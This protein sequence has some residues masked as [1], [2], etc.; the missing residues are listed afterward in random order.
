MQYHRHPSHRAP[1]HQKVYVPHGNQPTLAEQ[2]RGVYPTSLPGHATAVVPN[3]SQTKQ[4]AR[5]EKKKANQ[6]SDQASFDLK[7]GEFIHAGDFLKVW[8]MF[9]QGRRGELTLQSTNTSPQWSA[10]IIEK[11]ADFHCQTIVSQQNGASA[12][13]YKALIVLADFANQNSI[14]LGTGTLVNFLRIVNGASDSA[15]IQEKVSSLADKIGVKAEL[16]QISQ[17]QKAWYGLS[18]GIQQR[19]NHARKFRSLR[20]DNRRNVKM[21]R[22][23]FAVMPVQK[24]VAAGVEIESFERDLFV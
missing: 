5:D 18:V 7:V 3:Q 16:I 12:Q 11:L 24:I 9:Q 4:Q 21:H 8:A 22:I 6:P 2:L 23:K 15:I 17:R 13:S 14:N 19:K 10:Q 1:S 20:V